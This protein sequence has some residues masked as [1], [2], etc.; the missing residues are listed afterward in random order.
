MSSDK[1]SEK[2]G[3]I[4]AQKMLKAPNL[5]LAMRIFA[6]FHA[7]VFLVLYSIL[8]EF[9]NVNYYTED[10]VNKADSSRWTIFMRAIGRGC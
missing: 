9:E 2:V 1:I 4:I 6:Q 10:H 7:Q 3:K 5:K 8:V